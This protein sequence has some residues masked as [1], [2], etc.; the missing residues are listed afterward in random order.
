MLGKLDLQDALLEKPTFVRL[1]FL[2]TGVPGGKPAP[3]KYTVKDVQVRTLED[4]A[5][6]VEDW[7]GA[8]GSWQL[9]TAANWP[10]TIEAIRRPTTSRCPLVVNIQNTQEVLL[11]RLE[12]MAKESSAME[13]RMKQGFA[14]RIKE[15]KDHSIRIR[16]LQ[17]EVE[18]LGSLSELNTRAQQ[19]RSSR[20]RVF[21]LCYDWTCKPVL[22]EPALLLFFLVIYLILK[23]NHEVMEGSAV[24]KRLERNEEKLDGVKD[25]LSQVQDSLPDHLSD[26][27]DR[28]EGLVDNLHRLNDTV[29]DNMDKALQKIET[30][31][32]IFKNVEVKLEKERLTFQR[33]QNETLKRQRRDFENQEQ[34]GKAMMEKFEES[35]A[36]ALEKFNR[37][38]KREQGVELKKTQRI[39]EAMHDSVAKLFQLNRTVEHKLHELEVSARKDIK[40]A[41]LEEEKARQEADDIARRTEELHANSTEV[42]LVKMRR[43]VKAFDAKLEKVCRTAS[44]IRDEVAK[45]GRKLDK[46]GAELQRLDKEIAGL[47][48]SADLFGHHVHSALQQVA[49]EQ[50]R[51][52]KDNDGLSK[53]LVNLSDQLEASKKE[54]SLLRERVR[55]GHRSLSEN[56]TGLAKELIASRDKVAHLG[57][58]LDRVE[59]LAALANKSV[60]SVNEG[61]NKQASDLRAE[62]KSSLKGVDQR[63]QSVRTT[64]E[65]Y[66]ERESKKVNQLG[67]ELDAERDRLRKAENTEDVDWKK[68]RDQEKTMDD[69]I[70]NFKKQQASEEDQLNS[71]NK[72]LLVKGELVDD[73]RDWKSQE[74]ELVNDLKDKIRK[75]VKAGRRD[76]H[77]VLCSS[78]GGLYPITMGRGFNSSCSSDEDCYGHSCA[79]ETFK[80]SAGDG[81]VVEAPQPRIAVRGAHQLPGVATPGSASPIA[82]G[83]L[84]ARGADLAAPTTAPSL[85]RAAA[86]RTAAELA[87]AA[88]EAHTGREDFVCCRRGVA[89]DPDSDSDSD[90][91]ESV[92]LQEFL[93]R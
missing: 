19:A 8:P 22:R 12:D 4:V 48:S 78:C 69:S 39:T 3:P 28:V 85:A 52:Q 35:E 90:D 66:D 54:V 43:K 36:D 15:A 82:G 29:K 87:A 31:K 1:K 16:N 46:Q 38:F 72:S 74:E 51:M 84:R 55:Q 11:G 32:A 44:S 14:E 17:A 24:M 70:T 91:G 25:Q 7:L 42:A 64:I 50:S 33:Q 2:G 23:I 68:I 6:Q 88:T 92:R 89:E 21:Q 86:S 9:S 5:D 56:I 45:D 61:V 57:T 76:F 41:Q 59:H 18:K 75:I 34:E 20:A 81:F 10:L 13:E 49:A 40:E 58:S 79:K 26:L 30:S 73:L 63:V 65:S 77:C 47:N 93:F 67:T 53:K 71:L 83:A 60:A 80:F 37:T 62:V 27:P